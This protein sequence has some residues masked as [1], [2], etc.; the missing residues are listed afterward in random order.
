MNENLVMIP[1]NASLPLFSS[2]R[3]AN[4]Y[5]FFKIPIEMLML[6]GEL[7]SLLGE[8]SCPS[9]STSTQFYTLRNYT[10]TQIFRITLNVHLLM[11]R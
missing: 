6:S 4:G 3:N 1:H 2:I 9:G 11:I 5:L 7:R 8:L 10:A